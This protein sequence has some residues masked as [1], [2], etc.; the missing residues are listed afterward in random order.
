ML[1]QRQPATPTTMTVYVDSGNS[2]EGPFCDPST[3]EDDCVE[4]V[5]VRNHFEALG[6][7]IGTNLFY[8]LDVGGQHSE[9]YWGNRFPMPL[10]A[11]Y[12]I[13]P[14]TRTAPQN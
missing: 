1:A 4:T 14:T 11:L 12:G 10:L 7:Q 3:D 5:T 13:A 2:G 8:Y 6:W 9:V